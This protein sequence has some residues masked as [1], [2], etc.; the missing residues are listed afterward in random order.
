MSELLH[1]LETHAALGV[2]SP[3]FHLSDEDIVEIIAALRAAQ[4][5]AQPIGNR[6]RGM[7]AS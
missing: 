2:A 7:P 6:S 1:R 4:S 3:G 5:A